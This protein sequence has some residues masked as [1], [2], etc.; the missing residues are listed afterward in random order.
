MQYRN[1]EEL[2]LAV[3]NPVAMLR[4][5][6]IGAYV[7]PAVPTEFSNWR[8]EQRAWRAT[9]VLYDQSHHMVE[10]YVEGPD[11]IK[12]LSKLA[13]NS[14]ASFPVN[15]AKQFVPCSYDGYVIGDGI[16]FHLEENKLVF[17]GRAPSA[18]WI[19]FHAETSGYKV[20]T[21][22]DDRS[23]SNPRGKA[24]A[25]RNYRFQIQ[26]P[27]APQVIE[28]LNGGPVPDI[29]FF[30]VGV[31]NIAG[32]KVRALRHGMAGAPGLE[33][34]GPYEEREEIRAAIV[35]AGKDFGLKEV[36]SRAYATN[37]L[38]SGWIP[39]PLPAVYTGEKMKAYRQWLPA[40]SYEGTG[41]I[42][43]SFYSND[44]EDY[45]MSPYEL[46]YGP[47]VKFDHDFIGR[48]ALEKMA[49]KPHR[50]KVTLAWNAED[51]VKAFRSLFEPGEPYKYI[52]LPLSNYTSASYD[53]LLK[54]GKTVGVSMFSGYS[55]NERSM[56]SLAVVNPDIELGTEVKLVWGEESGG[57][58]K[59]TVERHKQIEIR[60]IVSPCPYSEVARTSYAEGWRSKATVA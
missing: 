39:S 28:K 9:A 54:G 22:K 40:A 11:A 50:K 35:N 32:R 14:F 15:R 12:M 43:G 3:G 44:I 57:S 38:E 48:E 49:G 42:G 60:A 17:V 10:Q 1:L 23:P 47:F 31:I 53:K 18:S 26:G 56:L 16:L 59:T 58:K 5:S 20:K 21:E 55:Y 34:W 6:Q 36:G 46:G 41:S 13:I 25:R 45:Y 29:K 2:L 27:N 19:Q 24:V 30:N 7:Y 52:D 37:T 33:V 51:V 4:D 8:D